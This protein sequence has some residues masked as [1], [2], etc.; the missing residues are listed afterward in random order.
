VNDLIYKIASI[1][2]KEKIA[3]EPGEDELKKY[4]LT[5]DKRKYL[6]ELFDNDEKK[7]VSFS[8]GKSFKGKGNYLYRESSKEV[9]LSKENL[10]LNS[11]YKDFVNTVL[12]EVKTDDI[13]KLSLTSDKSLEIVKKDKE[14]IFEGAEDKNYK[15]EKAE[16]YVK[17]L[18]SVSFDDFYSLTE[19]T[20]QS[21]RFDKDLRIKL[22]NNLIYKVSLAKDKE[23]HFMKITALFERP[24][25]QIVVNQ[26]DG[27][28]KL[29]EIEDVMNAQKVAQNINFEKGAWVYK[30]DKSVYENLVKNSDF[31][32]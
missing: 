29:Q 32:L 23:D 4:E 6:V 13:E 5:P 27:K 18:S 20:V 9:Y 8:V 14:F 24:P 12:F 19:P 7:T 17:N 26:N 30:V 16:E 15:K 25:T 10:L 2:V 22:K 1:Q 28:E 11:S 21:L 31:F 3:S